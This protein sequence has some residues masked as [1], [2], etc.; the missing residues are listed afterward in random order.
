MIEQVVAALDLG[1]RRLAKVDAIRAARL[2]HLVVGAGQR[3]EALV[4]HRLGKVLLEACA[5][6]ARRIDG[7]K[8]G[9]DGQAFRIELLEHARHLC[10]LLRANVGT[11][12]KAEI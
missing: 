12:G 10:E 7:D 11:L 4:Q 6:V 8:D 5:R 1:R 3:D 9:L 2:A